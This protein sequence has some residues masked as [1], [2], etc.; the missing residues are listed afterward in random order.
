MMRNVR[1]GERWRQSRGC[2]DINIH[3]DY[4]PVSSFEHRQL[5]KLTPAQ[6]LQAQGT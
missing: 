1:V 2:V 3:G 4:D 6:G 5:K